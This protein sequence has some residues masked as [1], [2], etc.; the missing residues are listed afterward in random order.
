LSAR[1]RWQGGE[2]GFTLVELLVATAMG[3]VLLGAIGSM[4]ISAMRSQP[5]VSKR[6][7]S[8]ST[9]RWVLER[10]TREIRNGVKVDNA[11]AS[12]VS[13]QTYV[14]HTSCGDTAQLPSISMSIKCE[15]TYTCT[16]TKCSRIEAA[17]L[18]Y[19]GTETTIFSGI[20]SSN[21]FD[22]SPSPA[23]ATYIGITLRM[24]NPS[25]PS[26]LTVSD[27]ASLRN[28]VLAN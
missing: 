7:N 22:Y 1:L 18:T 3:V 23:T 24:P 11:T 27:G 20:N 19:T 16:T 9:A 5:E 25:G 6:A 8:I 14:R 15:V 10:M 28:A 4:L 2:A 21:V 12:S 13:F 17:P 26:A